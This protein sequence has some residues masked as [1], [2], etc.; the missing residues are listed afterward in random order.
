M[1]LKL[2]FSAIL[3]FTLGVVMVGLLIFIPAN[4]MNYWN[5][6]LFM[7]LFELPLVIYY[8]KTN[9]ELIKDISI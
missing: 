1:N 2:F 8:F 6:W 4:T 9:K 7:I 5:G 3:K